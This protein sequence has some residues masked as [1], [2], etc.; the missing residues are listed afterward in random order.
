MQNRASQRRPSPPTSVPQLPS[1]SF[2]I[3]LRLKPPPLRLAEQRRTKNRNV[4]MR[5]K[6]KQ[7][8]ITFESVIFFLLVILPIRILWEVLTYKKYTGLENQKQN[9]KSTLGEYH[10]KGRLE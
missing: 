6:W 1:Y 7:V 10:Q 2:A 9:Q 3:I 4:D 5:A 8:M